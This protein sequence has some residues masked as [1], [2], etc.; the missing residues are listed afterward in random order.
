MKRF[1]TAAAALM[2]LCSANAVAA[3]VTPEEVWQNWQKTMATAGQALMADSLTREGDTL[4]AKGVKTSLDV[5]E[6][7]RMTGAVAEMRLRDLGDG[8]VEIT[9]SDLYDLR[10][11]APNTAGE[12]DEVIG[13]FVQPGMRAVASG[14]PG[15]MT[16]VYDV[17]NASVKIQLLT[18]GVSN[19]D[20]RLELVGITGS[21]S[22]VQAGEGGSSRASTEVQTLTF[23]I[24]TTEGGQTV[25]V[26][27][28]LAGLG[29]SWGGTILTPEAMKDMPAAL[30]AGA[31]F[32]AA[33]RFGAG[34]GEIQAAG[35]GVPARVNATIEAGRL[36]L[37]LN[38]KGLRYVIST[39]GVSVD[40]KAENVPLPELH[41]GYD[42]AAISL[43]LPVLQSDLPEDFGMSVRLVNLA[44][45]NELWDML[46]PTAVLPRGPASLIVET[47]GKMRFLADM[48][49][50]AATAALGEADWAEIDALTLSD[51]QLRFA[52]AEVLGKGDLTFDNADKTSLDGMPVPTGKVE[53]KL[54]GVNGLLD[55]LVAMGVF[56]PD[57]AMGFRMALA[58]FAKPG[59]GADVL[60]SEVEFRDKG[61][62]VNGQR[63]K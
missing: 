46:D 21:Y 45:S 61:I 27:G 20:A 43:T 15:E 37:G 22:L 56:P 2:T 39:T 14:E 42:E 7:A 47:S 63:L 33:I 25:D 44:V 19:G 35:R 24:T 8:T 18:K 29:V 13:Q 62:I 32:E 5:G 12:P 31:A 49:D 28:S 55:K 4:V 60:N 26:T 40:N 50:E 11:S 6:G 54:T 53:A 16:Y 51:L 23:A 34:S 57:Q 41:L 58:V 38:A 10:L 3:D 52:G 9:A 48:F 17:P 1:G 36:E 30:A 59:E